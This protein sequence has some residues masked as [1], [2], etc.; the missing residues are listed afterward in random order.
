M[1]KGPPAGQKPEGPYGESLQYVYFIPG[2]AA[3]AVVVAVDVTVEV[4]AD[5]GAGIGVSWFFWQPAKAKTV[6]TAK[7]AIIT[8]IFLKIFHLL[9]SLGIT[10]ARL[11]Q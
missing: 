7:T 2:I 9:S 3:G 10:A 6:T 8:V 1:H 11:S 4:T 5:C